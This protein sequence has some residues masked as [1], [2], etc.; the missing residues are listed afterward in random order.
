[1]GYLYIKKKG[2]LASSE[3]APVVVIAP[4]FSFMD[5][6]FCVAIGHLTY[7][8]R[9]ENNHVPIFGRKVHFLF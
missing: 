7:I 4:H 9:D 3:E 8:S 5:G 2:K 1:M 6:I